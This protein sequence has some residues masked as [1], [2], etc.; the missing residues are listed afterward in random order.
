MIGLGP[1]TMTSLDWAFVVL[2][3]VGLIAAAVLSFH[4]AARPAWQPA[5]RADR[6][7]EG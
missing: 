1:H 7:S 3:Q 6:R 5:R 4:L 2:L